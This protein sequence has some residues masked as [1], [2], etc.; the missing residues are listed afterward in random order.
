[1]F[2]F[3]STVDTAKFDIL[4]DV[5]A[6]YKAAVDREIRADLDRMVSHLSRTHHVPQ[7]HILKIMQVYSQE[8][9]EK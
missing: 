2:V 9:L 8:K 6:R 5:T 3:Q 4:A 1:M 7:D